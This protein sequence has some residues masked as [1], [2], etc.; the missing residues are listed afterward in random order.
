MNFRT[1]IFLAVFLSVMPSET[2]A[3][4]N[5]LSIVCSMFPVYDFAREIAGDLADVRLIMKPGI[6]PHE[7][8]PS[9]LDVKAL[10]DSDVFVYT[11]PLMEGWAVKLS[12]TLEHTLTIDASKGIDL[13]NDDPH[14][15]LDMSL[16][17]RMVNNIAMALCEADPDN[18]QAYTL[19][20]ERYNAKLA[21]LDAEFMAMNKDKPLVFAGEFSYGYFIRRYGF[22]YISAYDGENEPGIRRLAEVIRH[23][24]SSGARYILADTPPFPQVT[25]SISNQTSTGILTFNS[26]HKAQ[27]TGRT[28]LE[29]M[30]DNRDNIARVLND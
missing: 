3:K 20:A 9:P 6:E 30:S 21:G 2:F 18:S 14:I 19:N 11:G 24:T 17:Q 27:D 8:E 26:M 22:E 12:G 29:I 28:F 1:V 23:I 7:Y 16:A 4:D 13:V 15:W 10:N 25:L 5:K